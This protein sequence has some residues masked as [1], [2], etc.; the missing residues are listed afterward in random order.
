MFG[1]LLTISSILS[2]LLAAAMLVLWVRSYQ[3][4]D[5]VR[6]THRTGF[7]LWM[8]SAGGA[9]WL[10]ISRE[11]QPSRPLESIVPFDHHSGL[12]FR[13]VDYTDVR[14]WGHWHWQ[15]TTHRQ[16]LPVESVQRRGFVGRVYQRIRQ[17]ESV[18][19]AN[20][21][22]HVLLMTLRRAYLDERD[23]LFVWTLRA[24]VPIWALVPLSLVLPG[25]QWVLMLRARHRRLVGLCAACGYDV[26]AT[27]D[28]CPEC[29]TVAPSSQSAEK[30]V[31]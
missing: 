19:S 8:H 29:G 26:R 20:R 21:D 27:P 10:E 9:V 12:W 3:R 15:V 24:G 17:I 1:R 23:K 31:V 13:G 5:N 2:A 4:T 18:Q 11:G 28:R 22:P 7:E 30:P 16:P 25:T 6:L 14:G